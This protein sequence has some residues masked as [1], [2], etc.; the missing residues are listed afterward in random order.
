[1]SKV[2]INLTLEGE[3]A[4]RVLRALVSKG[5]TLS[6]PSTP[7]VVEETLE[8]E[9]QGKPSYTKRMM[10]RWSDEELEYLSL[11][12]KDYYQEHGIVSFRYIH[13]ELLESEFYALS[14]VP[15]TIKSLNV[16]LSIMRQG[17]NEAYFPE[18]KKEV[19]RKKIPK[20]R[21]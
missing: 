10:Q 9:P 13:K 16:R 11:M 8:K 12:Q 18:G 2:E 6:V 15:R 5:T 7:T 1:M 3:D 19:K 21:S 17:G 14:G 20:N 4:L